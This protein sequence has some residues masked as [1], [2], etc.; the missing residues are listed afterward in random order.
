[1]QP[2]G[3]FRDVL[4]VSCSPQTQTCFPSLLGQA[5]PSSPAFPTEFAAHGVCDSSSQHRDTPG[6]DLDG[7][8]PLLPY[9]KGHSTLQLPGLSPCSLLLPDHSECRQGST[10]CTR[11]PPR[12]LQGPKMP[13]ACRDRASLCPGRDVTTASKLR[14]AGAPQPTKDWSEQS[15]LFHVE[16]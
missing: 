13:P 5:N 3:N 6:R 10:G 12:D 15:L 2:G 14:L 9:P 11:D 4:A 16:N 8:I 7:H 1:M